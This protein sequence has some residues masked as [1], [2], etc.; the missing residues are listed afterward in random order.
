MRRRT[1]IYRGLASILALAAVATAASVYIEFRRE[2]AAASVRISNSDVVETPCGPI[3]YAVRGTG[4]RTLLFV[5]GAGGGFDQG[6]NF[7]E[8]ITQAGYRAVFVSRFGYLRTPLPADA[9]AAAQAD[10]HACLLDALGVERATVLSASAG[11]PSS[12]QFAIRHPERTDS[13]VLLVPAVFAPKPAG[14]PVMDAP[15]STRLVFE[16]VLRFDFLYWAATKIAPNVLM[17]ALL[18]TPVAVARSAPADEQERAY[19][20]LADI[21]PVHRRRLGLLNDAAVTSTMGRYDLEVIKAPT[22]AISVADD[23]FGTFEAARYTA[24]N[25]PGA[26]FVGFESGGHIW[27]GHHADLFREL[28]R[29]L[30]RASPEPLPSPVVIERRGGLA[31]SPSSSP[32]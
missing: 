14:Q 6:L 11:A 32:L 23:L 20:M 30:E 26:M 3:E 21:L 15:T 29:F 5:H 2:L 28:R 18:A 10:A 4:D 31:S 17:E 19:R 16:T 1:Q 27:L 24:T 13:L 22:L 9:S 12:L 7:A 8:S 25:I